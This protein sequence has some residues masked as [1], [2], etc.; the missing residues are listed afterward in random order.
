MSRTGLTIGRLAR[1]AEVGIETI[2]HYQRLGMLPTP[3]AGNGAFRVY[4]VG[5]VDRIRFIKRAQEHG[6]SLAEI[7]VLLRLDDGMHPREVR[8]VATHR[9]EEIR[10][11]IADLRRMEH[12]LAHLV[13]ECARTGSSRPCPIITALLG[14]DRDKAGQA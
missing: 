6:F 13:E 1:A 4:P 9:L 2:R 14:D 8:E 10:R 5:L 7:D 11:R 12:A 3:E